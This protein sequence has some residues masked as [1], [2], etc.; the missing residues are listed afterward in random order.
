L[1]NT[2]DLEKITQKEMKNTQNKKKL[3]F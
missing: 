2:Q 3:N 1:K